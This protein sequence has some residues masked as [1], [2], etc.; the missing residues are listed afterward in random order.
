M[1]KKRKSKKPAAP[2]TARDVLVK[3]AASRIENPDW[4]PDKD[5]EPG[6]P[7]HISGAVNVR[8]SAVDVLYSRRFL[9]TTQK[10]AADRFR[11]FWEAAGGVA[12]G[13]DYSQDRVDGGRGDPVVGRLRAAQEM[14][15][16]R[17]LLGRRG[18]E[19]VEAV[20][21]EGKSLTDLSPHKRDRLTMADNLRA[22]LDDLATMWGMKT[23]RK[24]AA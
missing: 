3:I 22:D 1:K 12:R 6:F 10:M 2:K 18:Y 8:E 19:T 4:T 16:C 7:R 17:Q 14:E 24:V 11:E 5:G 20:C 15:R 21:G 23:A 9:G 13:M